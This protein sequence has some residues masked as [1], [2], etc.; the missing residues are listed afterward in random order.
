MSPED[1]I[2]LNVLARLHSVASPPA[3]SAEDLKTCIRQQIA[4]ERQESTA[5]TSQPDGTG[6]IDPLAEDEIREVLRHREL[7]RQSSAVAQQSSSL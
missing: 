1:P 7:A 4:E 5:K 3:M 2:A 6:H